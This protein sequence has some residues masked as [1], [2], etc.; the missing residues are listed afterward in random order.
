MAQVQ[1]IRD[2][3][4]SQTLHRSN[5]ASLT[6]RLP[7]DTVGFP[8]SLQVGIQVY[9]YW[10]VGASGTVHSFYGPALEVIE[11]H[12]YHTLWIRAVT[13]SCPDSGGGDTE[14]TSQ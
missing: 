11:Y 4:L 10:E 8:L 3:P 14:P 6:E 2:C 5:T 12:F 1:I 9:T 13:N 7:H